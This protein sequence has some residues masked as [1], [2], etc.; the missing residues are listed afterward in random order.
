MHAKTNIRGA[1]KSSRHAQAGFGM[2]IAL[3]VLAVFAL[4]AGAIALANKGGASKTDLETAKTMATSIVNRGNELLQASQRVGQDR[5]IKTMTLTATS[6]AGTSFGLYDP[7]IGIATDVKIPGKAFVDPTNDVSFALDKTNYTV[8]GLGTGGT[9]VAAVAAILPGLTLQA[10][11]LI[12]KTVFNDTLDA[13]PATATANLTRNEG[14]LN[15][16]SSYTYYKVLGAA[17]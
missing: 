9:T 5:D 2:A 11:Q 16:S 10:C 17:A 6:T 8:V 13:T 12:N 7:A 15:V 1:R 4:I 14:C 3:A